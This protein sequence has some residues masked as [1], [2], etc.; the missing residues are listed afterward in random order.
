M[1]NL[2][3]FVTA[4]PQELKKCADPLRDNN[5]WLEEILG[6]SKCEKII[7]AWGSFKGAQERA[8]EVI[9]MF[10]GAYALHINKNGSPKHPLYIK[11]DTTPILYRK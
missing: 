7:F 5:R 6:G 1:M 8:K 3:A 9:K 4:Y 11:G 10:P 2:F